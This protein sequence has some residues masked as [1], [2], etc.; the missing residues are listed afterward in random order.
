M[1]VLSRYV[2]YLLSLISYRFYLNIFLD[3]VLWRKISRSQLNNIFVLKLV[4]KK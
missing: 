1:D 2:C 3:V 4:D